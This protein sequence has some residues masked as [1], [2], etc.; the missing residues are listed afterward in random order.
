VE[1]ALQELAEVMKGVPVEPEI[2]QAIN[3]CANALRVYRGSPPEKRAELGRNLGIWASTLAARM[4]KG[5]LPESWRSPIAALTASAKSLKEVAS[6]AMTRPISVDFKGGYV[7]ADELPQPLDNL[8][9]EAVRAELDRH[10]QLIKKDLAETEAK[11]LKFSDSLES[12]TSRAEHEMER[13][14]AAHQEA[15]KDIEARKVEADELLGH[16]ASKAVAGDYVSSAAIEA[17][18]AN[19]LRKWSVG[20][21]MVVVVIVGTTFIQS[22]TGNIEWQLVLSRLAMAFILTVPAGYLARE[23]AKHRQ[24]QYRYQQTSLE[25]R[26]ITPYLASLPPDQQHNLKVEIARQIFGERREADLPADLGIPSANE[27]ILRLIE[28]L[29]RA[30]KP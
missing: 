14:V 28:K 18:A 25:L 8:S 27:I 9:A 21:M 17:N 3:T 26:A 4:R 7:R 22:A 20:V 10:S 29:P 1:A 16:I 5:S 15:F 30:P 2:G 6:Q 24:Q 12:L 19:D 11:A 23:S 13:V